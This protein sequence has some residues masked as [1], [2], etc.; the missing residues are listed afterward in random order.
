MKIWPNYYYVRKYYVIDRV[1][2][3]L[4][5]HRA[6]LKANDLINVPQEQKTMKKKREKIAKKNRIQAM[7]GVLNS[8][9]IS[10]TGSRTPI[11]RA[12]SLND[13]RKS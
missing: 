7:L 8:R 2:F 9:G 10:L 11:S 1:L 3:A 12:L 6:S 5:P 13:K 4:L